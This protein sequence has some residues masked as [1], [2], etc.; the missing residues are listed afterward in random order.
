MADVF[1][2][3]GIKVRL[4]RIEKTDPASIS[5]GG[6]IGLGFPVAA[7]GTFK[8]LWDFFE[9]MPRSNGTPVFMVDTLSDFSG[10]IVGPLRKILQKKGYLPIGAKEIRMPSD[11]PVT[12]LDRDKTEKKFQKGLEEAE[13]Y[14]LELI[15][16]QSKWGRIPVLSDVM[17]A[18]SRSEKTWQLMRKVIWWRVNPQKCVKCRL[19]VHLCPVS[20]IKWNNFPEYGDSCYLCMRCFAFCPTDAIEPVSK[21]YPLK[22]YRAI[23]AS[24]ILKIRD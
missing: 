18:A 21:W 13:K 4:H 22:K 5:S 1:E 17:A 7:Q 9:N 20:N 8:F 2:Q 23:K 19:C 24:D 15:N 12:E 11:I 6:I 14:A 3:N 10:G 16:G